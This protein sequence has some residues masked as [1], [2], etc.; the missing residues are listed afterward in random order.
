MDLIFTAP[1]VR[2]RVV[3]TDEEVIMLSNPS[4]LPDR[5]YIDQI[6][7]PW[8]KLEIVLPKEHVGGVMKLCDEKRGLLKNISYIDEMRVILDYELPMANIITNFYDRLKSVSS[9]Y[10]SFSYEFLEYRKADLV[11]MDI[12]VADEKVDPLAMI[13]IRDETHGIGMAILKKLKETIPRHMFKVALQA[14]IGGKI[15]ARQDISAMSKNVTAKLYGG[16][17]TRKNKLLKKQAKGKKRMKMMGKVSLP[18]EAFLS[19]LKI[20]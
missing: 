4:M 7:E 15:V 1:S 3:K 10:A 18:Q 5:T 19:I 2:Y 14:A 11:K 17:V 8:V 13:I 9:G 20:D 16:D 6:Q 12:L